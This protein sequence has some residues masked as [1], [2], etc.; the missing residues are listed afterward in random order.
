[1]EFVALLFD[2]MFR[3]VTFRD[4]NDLDDFDII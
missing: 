4:V 2:S 3:Y 1:M